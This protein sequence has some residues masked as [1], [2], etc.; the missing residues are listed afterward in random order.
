MDGVELAREGKA[1]SIPSKSFAP[2]SDLLDS[3]IENG[4]RIGVCPPCGQSHDL[5]EEDLISE[6]EW[7]G[8]AAL[9]ELSASRQTFNF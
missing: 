8:G 5:S 1:A 6:A 3:F 7:M 2:V 4:G 9:V